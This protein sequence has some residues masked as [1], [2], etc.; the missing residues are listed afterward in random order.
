MSQEIL[1]DT[2]VDTIDEISL[3]AHGIPIYKQT[4]GKFFHSYIPT[5]YGS[6]LSTPIDAGI[7][8]IHF[9][10]YPGDYQPSGH[11]N[12]SRS[13][14]FYLKYTSSIIDSSNVG[15]LIVVAVALNF[16]II[17]DGSATLRYTT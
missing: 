14:E 2:Y 9:N 8:A 13:R 17:S 12:V 16:L 7:H 15:N 3:T 6:T 11:I 4:P 1:Y 5:K 10:L